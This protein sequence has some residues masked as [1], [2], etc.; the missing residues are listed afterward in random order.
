[1]SRVTSIY[2]ERSSNRPPHPASYEPQS[3]CCSIT[4]AKVQRIALYTLA[5]L[6]LL[7]GTFLI[8]ASIS[9]GGFSVL[10]FLFGAALIAASLA[11]FHF[12]FKIKDYE[13][14]AELAKM[15]TQAENLNFSKLLEEHGLENV[16]KHEIVS[17][18]TLQNKFEEYAM[19]TSYEDLIQKYSLRTISKEKLLSPEKLK[20]FLYKYFERANISDFFSKISLQELSTLSLVNSTQY[21]A[22]QGF[23]TDLN[24]LR[25]N[26]QTELR[27]LDQKFPN[28]TEIQLKKLNQE[29]EA[30][31]REDCQ[32]RENVRGVGS[33]LSFVAANQAASNAPI[34]KKAGEALRT[35]LFGE[36]ATAAA[37]SVLAAPSYSAHASI[38]QR[39]GEVAQNSTYLKAQL[40]YNQL[41][42]ETLTNFSTALKTLNELFTTFLKENFSVDREK[43]QVEGEG[44]VD[45]PLEEGFTPDSP[46]GQD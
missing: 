30:L 44:T 34:G 22:L 38:E 6:A 16:K 11:S 17:L 19:Y 26:K 21:Q 9:L 29:K 37:V 25:A 24:T 46:E 12:G 15:K 42:A 7:G 28:R 23:Q 20:N 10:T 18:E 13:D 8:A 45:H 2:P 14:P 43:G 41:K 36:V 31:T 32:R 39:K 5:T 40:Q 27:T 1:M 4:K 35:Q 33:T 3:K